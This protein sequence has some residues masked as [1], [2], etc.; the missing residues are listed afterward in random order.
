MSSLSTETLY[1]PLLGE[2]PPVAGDGH[3]VIPVAPLDGIGTA[4]A[5]IQAEDDNEMERECNK[6]ICQC[7]M[8]IV[9]FGLLALVIWG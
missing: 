6:C 7:C 2:E 4:L 9:V 5:E 1:Q 3:V 8:G